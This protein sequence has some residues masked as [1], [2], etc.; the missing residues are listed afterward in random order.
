MIEA[1][2]GKVAHAV[3]KREPSVVANY[4]LDL[5]GEFSKY[6]SAGMR[7]EQRRVL[8]EDEEV[9]NARLLLVDAIRIVISKGLQ[10]LGVAAPERM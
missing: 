8:C 7:E 4:L 5:C 6:Y 1:F 3:E 2:P 9:R 10:L